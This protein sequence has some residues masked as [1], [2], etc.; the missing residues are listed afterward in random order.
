MAEMK[1]LN[2][3]VARLDYDMWFIKFYR[4]RAKLDLYVMQ[5]E[6][7]DFLTEEDRSTYERFTARQRAQRN[8]IYWRGAGGVLLEP[9]EDPGK[10]SYLRQSETALMTPHA[11]AV[12][13][14]IQR[15]T[16]DS[17]GVPVSEERRVEFFKRIVLAVKEVLDANADADERELVLG[18]LTRI[19]QLLAEWSR[20]FYHPETLNVVD[21]DK[22]LELTGRAQVA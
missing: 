8:P 11:A 19:Q 20:R 6:T 4:L 17:N 2:D 12:Q 18:V 1:K 3:I 13:A 10:L 15:L 14:T 22:L 7:D 21:P 9:T 5:A 16:H